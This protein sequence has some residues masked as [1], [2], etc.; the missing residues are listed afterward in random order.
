MSGQCSEQSCSNPAKY[1]CACRAVRYCGIECRESDWAQHKPE[2]VAWNPVSAVAPATVQ[3]EPV[4]VPSKLDP[5]PLVVIPELVPPRK[6]KTDPPLVHKPKVRPDPYVYDGVDL[7]YLWNKL[8]SEMLDYASSDAPLRMMYDPTL[9][10]VL[11]TRQFDEAKTYRTRP[12][13]IPRLKRAEII[14]PILREF[15]GTMDEL[16]FTTLVEQMEDTREAFNSAV[17]L[18]WKVFE[19]SGASDEQFLRAHTHFMSYHQRSVNMQ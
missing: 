6:G 11:E 7:R 19:F 10:N 18:T 1:A 8:P 17:E 16:Y 3:P 15:A 9:A 2:C 4:P 14:D 12:P 13:L 5:E